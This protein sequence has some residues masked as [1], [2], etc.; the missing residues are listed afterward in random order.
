MTLPSSD[1]R[2][3]RLGHIVYELAQYAARDALRRSGADSRPPRAAEE[4]GRR[5]EA[6]RRDALYDELDRRERDY[7]L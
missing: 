5:G 1:P 6:R 2:T 7:K 3:M 4:I